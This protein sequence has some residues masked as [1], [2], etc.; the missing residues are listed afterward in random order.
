MATVERIRTPSHS[1]ARSP[2]SP[3]ATLPGKSAALFHHQSTKAGVG[4]TPRGGPNLGKT[5]R[6]I[7]V[8]LCDASPLFVQRAHP[9]TEPKGAHGPIGGRGFPRHLWHAKYGDSLART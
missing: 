3:E 1:Y 4:F 7:C 8:V 5:A 6:V 9:P 2:S